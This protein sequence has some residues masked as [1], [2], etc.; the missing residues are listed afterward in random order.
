MF[1]ITRS[2]SAVVLLVAVALLAACTSAPTQAGSPTPTAP[3]ASP[4]SASA[5]PSSPSAPPAAAGP[6]VTL[7]TQ[8]GQC[9][10]G[11]CD[12]TVAIDADG[13]VRQTAPQTAEL[14]TVSAPTL[15]ALRTEIDQADFGAIKSHPF[16]DACPIAFDGQ[17]FIY[18][19]T[20]GSSFETI[21]SCV[22]VVD[23]ANPLFVAVSAALAEVRPS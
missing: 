8:G 15:E 6:L 2:S 19:F 11:S 10:A 22:V 20:T 5:V 17:Q 13:T 18:R 1:T 9:M 7:T 3:P 14:G 4:S 23:P 16:T 21:D 12:T